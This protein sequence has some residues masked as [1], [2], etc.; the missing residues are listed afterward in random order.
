MKKLS[1]L[2]NF[3]YDK[4]Y[5][6]I[7]TLED[8]RKKVLFKIKLSIFICIFIAIA[9]ITTSY[10]I[11]LLKKGIDPI[12]WAVAISLALYGIL[13]KLII[14]DYRNDFKDEVIQ[15]IVSFLEPT[16]KYNKNGYIYK[17]EFI[18]SNLF[19]KKI[20]RYS[21]NDLVEGKIE[22]TNIKFSDIKAEYKTTSKNKTTWHT[23]FR[24]QFFMADLNKEFNDRM[25]VL[26]DSAEKLLGGIGRFLQSH[27][28]DRD[29]LIKLDNPEFEK[30]FVVYANDEITSRYILTHSMMQRILNFK[31]KSKKEIYLSF[32]NS[33]IFVA[34][35][36]KDMLEPNPFKPLN[37]FN[38]IKEYY[39]SF[40][41]V[42]DIV[43][44][45]KLNRRI[46]SKK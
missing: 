33:K 13:Y 17:E 37:D 1:E 23:I 35:S 14:S 16:L 31:K 3:Y 7:E 21:G 8:D 36:S 45:L 42:V 27:N 26:P 32:R 6:Q 12:Y 22:E 43:N 20:D 46:W 30:E 5:P 9:I 10:Y 25:V 15:K 28:P 44:E 38:T 29:K 4:I 11:G 40:K 24:G 39:E 2:M 34:V 19:Q 41:I 18:W